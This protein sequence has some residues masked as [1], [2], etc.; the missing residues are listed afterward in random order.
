MY[1]LCTLDEQSYILRDAEA[2]VLF[3]FSLDESL[4]RAHSTPLFKVSFLLLFILLKSSVQIGRM[5]SELRCNVVMKLND[6][7]LKE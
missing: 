6:K 4:K 2:E 7:A 1:V 5:P 3:D